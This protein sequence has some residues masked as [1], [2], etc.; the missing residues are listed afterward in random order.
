V[1]VGETTESKAWR[2]A[3]P[4]LTNYGDV[5]VG[6][7]HQILAWLSGEGAIKI[8]AFVHMNMTD[9]KNMKHEKGFVLSHLVSDTEQ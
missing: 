1:S 6:L 9:L 8:S 7:T 4:Y 3:A 2:K 5:C